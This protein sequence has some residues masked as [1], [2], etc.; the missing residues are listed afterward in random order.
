MDLFLDLF[1]ISW[2]GAFKWLIVGA[3]FIGL[4]RIPVQ[5]VTFILKNLIVTILIPIMIFYK[6]MMHLDPSRLNILPQYCLWAFIFLALSETVSRLISKLGISSDIQPSFHLVNTFNN[7]G[8]VAYGLVESLYGPALLTELFAFVIFTEI[9]LWTRG[10]AFFSEETFDINILIKNLPL[11]S[12]ILALI[13]KIIDFTPFGYLGPIDTGI[14]FVVSWTVP[15][16]ILGLGG[17]IYHQKS[18]FRLKNIFKKEVSYAL[19]LR[20]LIMP[21]LLC[22]LIY[23]LTEENLK[24][25]MMI[26][27]VMPTAMMVITLAKIYGGKAEVISLIVFCSQVLSLITIPIWLSLFIG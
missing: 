8:F 21:P 5:A 17:L 11:W 16:A 26:E 23:Y 19:I 22:G 1:Q 4:F 6:T 7:Y 12:F 27:A 20:H 13:F 15:L 24:K 2:N 14:E 9:A 3:L 18:H 25:A 10:R